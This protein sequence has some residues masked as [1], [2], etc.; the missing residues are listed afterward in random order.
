M[1]YQEFELSE[2]FPTDQTEIDCP[3]FLIVSLTFGKPKI[4]P[5]TSIRFFAAFYVVCFHLIGNTDVS[6][7]SDSVLPR[8]LGYGFVSVSFFFMLSG[9]VLALSYLDTGSS[10]QIRAFFVA[11]FARLY[12]LIV[13]T[14]L[15]DIP[16]TIYVNRRAGLS[17]GHILAILLNSVFVT[18]AW[19]PNVG[20][21][22]SPVWSVSVEIFFYLLMPWIGPWLWRR[23]GW[24]LCGFAVAIYTAGNL[25]VMYVVHLRVNGFVVATNPLLHLY[26]FLLGICTA[27]LFLFLTRDTVWSER[28]ARWAPALIIGSALIFLSV[29][30]FRL[31]KPYELMQHGILTPLYAVVL[32]A[33]SSGHQTMSRIFSMSWLVILGEASFA[34]YLIHYPMA[35]LLRRMMKL[36]PVAGTGFYLALIIGLSIGSTFWLERPSRRWIMAV[37]SKRQPRRVAAV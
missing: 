23:S 9:Y 30:V 36:H 16:H 10:L 18:S 6:G 11:R 24:W 12:P 7:A 27:K 20:S 17:H 32:L 35:M 19:L 2:R 1:A 8:I 34:L 3:G 4:L 33:L 14:M 25:A 5:V 28:L 37:M 31:G 22:D 13:A 21:L 29:P 15:L 26:E